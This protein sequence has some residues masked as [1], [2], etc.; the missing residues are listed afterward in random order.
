ME[1]VRW[2][3]ASFTLQCTV[4]IRGRMSSR[5]A[6]SRKSWWGPVREASR[7]LHRELGP[8]R[9]YLTSSLPVLIAAAN[10]GFLKTRRVA[11]SCYPFILCPQHSPFSQQTSDPSTCVLCVNNMTLRR[12][13]LR[14]LPPLTRL[15]PIPPDPGQDDNLRRTHATRLVLSWYLSPQSPSAVPGSWSMFATTCPDTRE[16]GTRRGALRG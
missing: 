11:A 1:L 13:S 14:R 9:D 4:M 16:F 2:L 7:D 3:L 8:S 10:A 6:G 15:D 12:N 5:C